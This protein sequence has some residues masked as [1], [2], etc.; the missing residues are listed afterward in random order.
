MAASADATATDDR[1]RTALDIA[2]IRAAPGIAVAAVEV[3][4]LP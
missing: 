1:G 4:H 3:A 2:M